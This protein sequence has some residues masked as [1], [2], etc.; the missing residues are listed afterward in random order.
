M[1]VEEPLILFKRK[2]APKA[3]SATKLVKL[4][5]PIPN[6]LTFG[7][8]LQCIAFARSHCVIHISSD[9]AT[10]HL[11]QHP[12][13]QTLV[14]LES[15]QHIQSQDADTVLD[16]KTMLAIDNLLTATTMMPTLN[17]SQ[18]EQALFKTLEIG[19]D[20]KPQLESNISA[21][22]LEKIPE[23]T[24]P[25]CD[26]L[27]VKVREELES[28]RRIEDSRTNALFTI[29]CLRDIAEN[30]DGLIKRELQLLNDGKPRQSRCE[31]YRVKK[32]G[33]G[34]EEELVQYWFTLAPYHPVRLDRKVLHFDYNVTNDGETESR[35]YHWGLARPSYVDFIKSFLI[36]YYV[37][38]EK[39]KLN[40][41]LSRIMVD[42]GRCVEGM[43]R[44]MFDY[45]MSL[46]SYQGEIK[47]EIPKTAFN[48]RLLQAHFV[49]SNK[50]YEE[51]TPLLEVAVR[52][53]EKVLGMTMAKVSLEAMFEFI[54]QFYKG[55]LVDDT[56]SLDDLSW[57]KKEMLSEKIIMRYLV[58][59]ARYEPSALIASN[60]KNLRDEL[61]S[62]LNQNM[63]KH[64]IQIGAGYTLQRM[65]E[66]CDDKEMTENPRFHALRAIF[67]CRHLDSFVT[68]KT[69]EPYLKSITTLLV[70]NSE[71]IA[72]TRKVSQSQRAYHQSI[73]APARK[74]ARVA[75]EAAKAVAEQAREELKQR[76]A[77]MIEKI[78]A[79][80]EYG[81]LRT[82]QKCLLPIFIEL[83]LD[84]V[85]H[86]FQMP[87]T[88][89][90][91]QEIVDCCMFYIKDSFHLVLAGLSE[92]LRT[93]ELAI[94]KNK[95]NDQEPKLEELKAKKWLLAEICAYTRDSKL[96]SQLGE[97]SN[98][99]PPAG[100]PQ[101]V[102]VAGAQRPN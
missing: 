17:L 84:G 16:E 76:E 75:W 12:F 89:A 95:N 36:N 80:T 98:P 102:P 24:L 7:E 30:L 85:K 69:L 82:L 92:Q 96:L 64:H 87:T 20:F 5:D 23:M 8:L 52:S 70:D 63:Q 29:D 55:I 57:C 22:I 56:Q 48:D 40:E 60:N 19:V 62:L 2:A 27:L 34:Y 31:R 72:A 42:G 65:N 68:H 37:A 35:F 1:N 47:L 11:S 71:M 61:Q 66:A 86:P 38:L 97:I 41:A 59:L 101:N 90:V 100:P 83:T 78:K 91:I 25:E 28:N 74:K 67:L 44:P 79:D 3:A 93:E 32:K 18:Q 99:Q 81:Q 4:P 94:S 51:F 46:N 9:P 73:Q 45:L 58:Q 50:T 10:A 49:K 77:T 14:S 88:K 39:D 15:S 33:G 21:N 6:Q 26:M 53:A 13:I 54:S 43:V